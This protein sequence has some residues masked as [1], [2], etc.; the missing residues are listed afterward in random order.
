VPQEF[1]IQIMSITGKI[2]KEITRQELGDIRIGTNITE[3]KWDGTDTYGQKLGNGVYLYR[4]ISSLDG[5]QMDKFRLNDTYDQQGLDVTD[6]YFKKGYGK[7]VIL[8]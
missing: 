5:K 3:Y 1:K 6:Q 4:V 7:M 2:V 8:R